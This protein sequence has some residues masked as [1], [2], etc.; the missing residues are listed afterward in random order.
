M[1][2][3]NRTPQLP[4][5]TYGY[6][7]PP[8]ATAHGWSCPSEDCGVTEH[9]Q[10]RKWPKRC[11]NCGS[12]ADPVFD[13]VL[14]DLMM[15]ELSG[16]DFYARLQQAWPSMAERVIFLTGGAVSTRAA[17]FLDRV[18]NPRLDKPFDPTVL[19]RAVAKLVGG[20]PSATPPA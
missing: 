19:R 9:E 8:E 5:T 13:V 14:C 7:P 2:F 16:M 3:F 4:L 1:S 11:T 6:Q 17:Q 18:P 10:V 15:P 20:E 12:L